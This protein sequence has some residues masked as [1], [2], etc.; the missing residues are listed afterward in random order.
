M[1]TRQANRKSAPSALQPTSSH[2]DADEITEA[3]SVLPE[4]ATTLSQS[5]ASVT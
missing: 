1:K 4:S 2:Q 5:T 3:E